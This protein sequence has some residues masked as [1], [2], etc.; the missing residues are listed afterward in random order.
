[1][2][3]TRHSVQIGP[4]MTVLT[5]CAFAASSILD[6]EKVFGPFSAVNTFVVVRPFHEGKTNWKLTFVLMADTPEWRGVSVAVQVPAIRS[7]TRSFHVAAAMAGISQRTW[8][9]L[10]EPSF[11]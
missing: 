7:Q 3:L 5:H 2:S 4:A 8:A 9:C 10:R 1:M 6:A 11:Q